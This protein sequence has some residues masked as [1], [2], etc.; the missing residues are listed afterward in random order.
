MKVENMVSNRSQRE[1]PNQFIIT[2][3]NTEVFQSYKTIVIKIKNGKTYIDNGYPFST[4]TSKYASAFLGE[5]SKEIK[6]KIK[7]GEY[8]LTDLNK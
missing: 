1:I 3:G 8:I 7:T 4:T 6:R 5:T 2:D